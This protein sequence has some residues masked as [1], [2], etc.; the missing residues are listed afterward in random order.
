V[1]A[2]GGPELR[3]RLEVAH[4]SAVDAAVAHAIEFVPMVR[5]RVDRETVVR[6]RPPDPQL[7]SHVLVHAAVRGDGEVVAAESRAW[8]VHQR[9]VGA[10]YRNPLVEDGS[11]R[12]LH[13]GEDLGGLRRQIGCEGGAVEL[14]GDRQLRGRIPVGEGVRAGAQRLPQRRGGECPKISP[15]D[16]F[17]SRTNAAT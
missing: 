3:E 10:A 6:E 8:L 2:L 7:H 16:S 15:N 12:A 14:R 17:S 11:E 9:E 13:D 1:W 5:R 4:E